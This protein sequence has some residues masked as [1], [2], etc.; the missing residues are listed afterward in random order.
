MVGVRLVRAAH[1]ALV[2]VFVVASVLVLSAQAVVDPRYVEFNASA[3]HNTQTSTGTPFVSSY[4]LSLYPQG[5]SVA[6]ATVSL[7]KPTPDANNLIR[8]D[9]LPLLPSLPT[10][11]L[12]FEARVAAVGPGGTTASAVSNSFSF[13]APCAPSISPT[14]RS[15]ASSA[16][17]GSV[18]VTAGATCTWSAVSN[19]PSW[20]SL[21]GS[22]TGLGNGTV[23][24]SV[25]AN[26][27]PTQRVGSVTIAGQ[28]FTVTQS[29]VTCSASLS[30][31]SASVVA[32]GGGGST[33]VTSPAG[34]SWTAVT[35]APSWLSVT[36]GSSGSG[37]GT[38]SFSATANTA[39]QTRQGTITVGGQTFTVNQAAAAC[40]YSVSPQS[41]SVGAAGGN[42]SAS[43]TA[44]AGCAWTAASNAP[45]WLSISAGASG[46]GNGTVTFAASANTATQSRQGTLA[47]AGQTYTVNQAALGCTFSLT[48]V[49]ASSPSAGSTG[50]TS[51]TAPAGCAWTASS[52]APGWL[53]VSAGSSGDGNGTI[54]YS[55]A[56]NTATQTRQGT[57]TIGGQTFTVNQAA[58]PCTYSVSP[59]SS[60]VGAGGG[61]GTATV[62]AP[63]GCAWTATTNTPAWLTVS[64]GAS[65]NGDGTVTFAAAVNPVTQVRQGTLTIAGQTFTVNQAAAGCSFSLT[66]I[67]A[68]IAATG[69]AGSTAIS[70]PAGCV[71]N[72]SSNALSWLTITAGASGSGNGTISYSA[73]A[74]TQTQTR[75]GTLTIGGQT[76]TVNQAAASCSYAISPS[77]LSVAANGGSG[78]TSLTTTASC[79]WTAVSNVSWISV[80]TAANGSGNAVVSFTVA[81]NTS[82]SQRTGTLTIGGR[83]FTVSQAANTSCTYSLSPASQT[84]TPGGGPTTVSLT[85]G[86]SCFWT[87]TTTAGW[88]TLSQAG[89]GSRSITF[90]V[91]PNTS[92]SSRTGTLTIGGQTHTVNQGS[93]TQPNS[94]RNL[95]VVIAING[96]S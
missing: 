19:A 95:R 42:G 17:T 5:S 27:S 8:V 29:G 55:V 21:T 4:S 33:T 11:G 1:H 88:M 66:P 50:S 51:I 39:T 10:P 58:A 91:T 45:S 20:I 14:S 56:A 38:V 64:A 43:V 71:W 25:A 74:N 48:P 96:G 35:N 69:A 61:G 92:G 52:D 34:C 82:S 62:D 41:G 53:S 60:S 78:S 65:G 31:T 70:A 12:N 90:T 15:V 24:Y 28:T 89:S 30:P 36:A 80:T 37:N 59:L 32:S 73:A 76:F 40:S 22:T 67:S 84:V 57:L 83:T 7:G 75:Q 86:S 81:G 6:F 85:T 44:A 3:D 26:T 77:A 16:T 54:S 47:I 68:S 94:P 2:V 9:F 13:T 93:S 18:S 72:A 23:A 49:S 46:S 79:A 63:A 87:A